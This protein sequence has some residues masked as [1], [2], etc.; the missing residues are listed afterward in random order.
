MWDAVCPKEIRTIYMREKG[1]LRSKDNFVQLVRRRDALPDAS[2]FEIVKT[3]QTKEIMNAWYHFHENAH[4]RGYKEF[5]SKILYCQRVKKHR[6]SPNIFLEL[7]A[8]RSFLFLEFNE[9]GSSPEY[10]LLSQIIHAY[11][12]MASQYSKEKLDQVLNQ[13]FIPTKNHLRRFNQWQENLEE[14]QMARQQRKRQIKW[15]CRLSRQSTPF[16]PFAVQIVESDAAPK[17]I[18]VQLDILFQDYVKACTDYAYVQWYASKANCEKGYWKLAIQCVRRHLECHPSKFPGYPAL[19]FFHLFTQNAEKLLDASIP[20]YQFKSC[21]KGQPVVTNPNTHQAR[22]KERIRCNILLYDQLLE[23]FVAQKFPISIDMPI[24]E[25]RKREKL[26][27]QWRNEAKFIFYRYSRY[28][29]YWHFD[30]HDFWN[31]SYEPQISFSY[32]ENYKDGV[33]FFGN[34][35][36]FHINYCIPNQIRWLLPTL[37]LD[38]SERSE[39]VL[40]TLLLAEGTLQIPA[41]DRLI[42]RIQKILKS[43]E[44]SAMMKTY[45]RDFLDEDAVKFHLEKWCKQYQLR[46]PRQEALVYEPG[47]QHAAIQGAGQQVLEYFLRDQLVQKARHM[48]IEAAKDLFEGLCFDEFSCDI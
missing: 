48:L 7:I 24:I 31:T 1:R 29:R 22:T 5:Y 15:F 17:E 19:V 34:M 20:V 8:D 36:R 18:D 14:L 47:S 2:E 16:S 25:R 9:S 27:E 42:N 43:K 10:P 45:T 4:H 40:A 44:G 21:L 37:S 38:R 39:S 28:D 32:S 46:V 26:R 3:D 23:L 33:D 13:A 11:D 35:L 30:L 6:L 41:R 12:G